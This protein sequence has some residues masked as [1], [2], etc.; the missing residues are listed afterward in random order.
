MEALLKDQRAIRGNTVTAERVACR[1]L[2]TDNFNKLVGGADGLLLPCCHDS[3]GR[4]IQTAFVPRQMAECE[5]SSSSKPPGSSCMTARTNFWGVI[6][7]L[8]KAMLWYAL[9]AQPREQAGLHHPEPYL[10]VCICKVLTMAQNPREF[11]AA[12][13]QLDSK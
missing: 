13:W 12:S 9:L 3:A 10:T 7:C 6:Y 5:T 4:S 11:V 1:C 2:H 8:L